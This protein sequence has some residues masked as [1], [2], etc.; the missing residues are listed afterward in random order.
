GGVVLRQNRNIVRGQAKTC[1]ALSQTGVLTST[2]S[3]QSAKSWCRDGGVCTV[4][5]GSRVS[6]HSVDRQT[7]L[8][9]Q[10]TTNQ[11]HGTAA[12][13]LEGCA[14][15]TVLRA[16]DDAVTDALGGHLLGLSGC[17]HIADAG[18]RLPLNVIDTAGNNQVSLTQG[19]LV[20]AFFDGYRSGCTC[21][22][23]VNHRTVAAN[24]RLHGVRCN[25]V[26]QC[27]LQDVRRTVL[28]E[29]TGNEYL[30][31]RLHAADA[32]ALRGCNLTWVDNLQQLRWAEA[33]LGK[34]INCGDQVPDSHAVESIQHVIW[35]AP[36]GS[37]EVVWHLA[38]NS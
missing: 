12:V 22:D 2:A 37:I 18:Q 19:N 30:V 17:V 15:A 26:R 25:N 14:A 38:R 11:K 20:H 29:Q 7:H 4:A 6:N 10:R 32:G 31:Q 27:L 36:L 35:D 21:T 23:W 33:C 9:S 3:T 16:L 28:A 1:Q 5:V 13:C 8:T 34:R 24:Q